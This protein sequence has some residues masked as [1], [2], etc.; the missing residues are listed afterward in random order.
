MIQPHEIQVGSILEYYIEET[1]EWLPT[2]MDWQDIRNCTED[3]ADFNKWRRGIEI[4]PRL[5]Y[6]WFD[7]SQLTEDIPFT[8][9]KF[10]HHL[11]MLVQSLTN[12]PLKIEIK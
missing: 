1:N 8:K 10:V 7:K 6:N 12:N 9:C 4:T 11:Q 3:N 5:F 2:A